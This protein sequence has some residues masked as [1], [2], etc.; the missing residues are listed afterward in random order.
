M[1]EKEWLVHGCDSIDIKILLDK[2]NL[3]EEEI[4]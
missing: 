3:K 2:V 4:D 1:N